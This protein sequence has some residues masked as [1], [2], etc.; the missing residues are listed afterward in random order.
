MAC[1]Q[2]GLSNPAPE[3]APAQIAG[4]D[5]G[6]FRQPRAHL[7]G[8]GNQ[9]SESVHGRYNSLHIIKSKQ[10]PLKQS[11]HQND[12]KLTSCKCLETHNRADTCNTSVSCCFKIHFK[13]TP[14]KADTS[15]A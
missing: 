1:G 7:F 4:L 13:K 3:V 9:Q 10:K 8:I 11:F 15:G 2:A 6:V 12:F 5:P 14:Y